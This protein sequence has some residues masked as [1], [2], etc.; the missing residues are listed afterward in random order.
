MDRSRRLGNISGGAAKVKAHP[1]FAGVDWD[2]V[3]QRR[4][5]GPIIPPIRY[6]GDAQCFDVYPE[7]DVA[8]DPYTDELA[9]RYDEYFRISRRAD[10]CRETNDKDDKP[11]TK[12]TGS[13][14]VI[15]TGL[16]RTTDDR[17]ERA[18]PAASMHLT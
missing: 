8:K 11:I 6:P 10:I 16:G 15:E 3:I 4:R 17:T 12:Q 13:R 5:R 14:S 1:F 2:A 7:E 9:A 18:P